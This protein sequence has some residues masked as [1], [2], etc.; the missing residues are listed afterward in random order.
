MGT[1]QGGVVTYGRI[2]GKLVAA[3]TK[4]WAS[5]N[6][7]LT[8]NITD[9]D[10]SNAYVVNVSNGTAVIL[11]IYVENLE[12]TTNYVLTEYE[13]AADSN[14]SVIIQGWMVSGT[15]KLRIVPLSAATGTGSVKVRK[16]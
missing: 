14:T 5:A 6:D 10:P 2:D 1:I 9:E 15:G 4:T 12:G 3:G 16:L 11:D 13:V 7:A 8:V